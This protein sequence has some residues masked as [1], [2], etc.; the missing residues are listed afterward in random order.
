MLHRLAKDKAMSVDDRRV[1]CD[2][3]NETLPLPT[4]PTASEG[5]HRHSKVWNG[6]R[7]VTHSCPRPECATKA[8]ALLEGGK[9]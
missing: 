4:S 2:G 9:K 5:W 1:T 8:R 7:F 3:C 6:R